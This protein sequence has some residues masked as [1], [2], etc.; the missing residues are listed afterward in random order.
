MSKRTT[1]TINYCLVCNT[2]TQTLHDQAFNIDY[3]VCP[4]CDFIYKQTAFHLNPQDEKAR[5]LL[6]HNEELNIGYQTYMENIVKLHIRPLENVKTILDFGSG[7]YPMLKK[8][9][10]LYGYEVVDYDPYFN[11]NTLYD[12]QKYDLIIMTEVLE[13][14]QKPMETLLQLME[15]M[16]PNGKLL[17][18]TQ[19]RD[20]NQEQFLSWWY[21]RD[22]THVSFFNETTFDTICDILGFTIVSSNH[23]DVIILQQ[24]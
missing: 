10:D 13:H 6:H 21:R 8:V 20:M 22:Q 2:E 14:V 11:T 3:D 12:T 24:K 19:F 1:T 17:I 15:L 4:N 23:K 18:M 7:P 5:Y 16:E 9:L